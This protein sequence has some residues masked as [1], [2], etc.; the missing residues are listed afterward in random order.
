MSFC[1]D[2]NHVKLVGFF[3]SVGPLSVRG[4]LHAEFEAESKRI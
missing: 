1:C 2:E 4:D 3:F